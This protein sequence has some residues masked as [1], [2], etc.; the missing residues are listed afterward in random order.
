MET[1]RNPNEPGRPGALGQKGGDREQGRDKQQR[2]R[3]QRER[4]NQG[5]AD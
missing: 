4:E 5:G 2:E 1:L 3:Q